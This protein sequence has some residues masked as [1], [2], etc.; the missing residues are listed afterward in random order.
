M[1]S[2]GTQVIARSKSAVLVRKGNARLEVETVLSRF[3]NGRVRTGILNG[4]EPHV[5]S[6]GTSRLTFGEVAAIHEFGAP[7]AHI[8]PRSFLWLGTQ[9]AK[10][11]MKTLMAKLARQVQKGEI[12]EQAAL[13]KIG[14]TL[15]KYMR[16]TFKDWQDHWA[17]LA[18]STVRG[19]GHAEPLIDTRQLYE[20][21][22][23][24]VDMP[25]AKR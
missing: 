4:N 8:P 18:P 13:R 5:D 20:A 25:G 19:K 9:L 11:F 23:S 17:P 12:T 14:E 7:A 1:A 3:A 21:I 6:D 10:P 22:D 15:Q 16:R 24:M 2:G